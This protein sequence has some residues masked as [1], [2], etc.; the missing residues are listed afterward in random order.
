ME[1]IKKRLEANGFNKKQID[2]F[3]INYNHAIELNIPFPI[4]YAFLKSST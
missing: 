2:R 3:M 4:Y 1:A